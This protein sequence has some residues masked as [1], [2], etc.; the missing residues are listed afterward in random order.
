MHICNGEWV[1]TVTGRGCSVG[2]DKKGRMDLLLLLLL[3]C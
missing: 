2:G 1:T 3:L